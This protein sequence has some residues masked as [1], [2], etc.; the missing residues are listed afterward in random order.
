[1]TEKI[2]VHACCAPCSTVPVPA[3]KEQGF[4]VAT[5][6]FNPNIH[7]Y[8]EFRNRL[9]SMQQ[10]VKNTGVTGFFYTGYP[11]E[12]FLRVQLS[13]PESRCEA[14][15]ELRLTAAANKAR[16]EGIRLFSTTLLVSPYQKHDLIRDV[17]RTVQKATGVEFLYSDWRPRWRETRT[18]S[19]EEGLYLQKYC[20]CIF[21]EKERYLGA[22][23][24]P[25]AGL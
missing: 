6:F 15:Y 11:L 5:F 8:T 19:R 7:P 12:K 1:M 22:Q 17:G 23:G 9:M 10:F 18:I 16:E 20:G 2:L 3:L 4:D 24:A 21:S 14:C 13:Q 25:E